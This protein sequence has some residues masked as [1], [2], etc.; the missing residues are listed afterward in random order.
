MLKVPVLAVLSAKRKTG[1]TVV[2]EALTS[3]LVKSGLRVAAAKHIAKSRFTLDA[4]GTD[5]R[6]LAE[7]GAQQVVAVTGGEVVNILKTDTSGLNLEALIESFKPADLIVLEGFKS[8]VLQREDVVKII[9]SD[10]T[11]EV[12]N[13]LNTARR[14]IAAITGEVAVGDNSKLEETGIPLV[15]FPEETARLTKLVFEHYRAQR[16]LIETL[17]SLGGLDCGDCGY[18]TCYEHAKAIQ[19]VRS[20]LDKCIVIRAGEK[21]TVTINGVKLPMK[22]FVQDIIQRAVLGMVSSLQKTDIH[23]DERLNITITRPTVHASPNE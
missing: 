14:P 4:P 19:A 10:D 1:K 20:S 8:L 3:K 6:R 22:G 13:L 2:A 17:V 9:V 23:G 21:V 16:A 15:R 7:A 12:F 18:E 11:A 5:T